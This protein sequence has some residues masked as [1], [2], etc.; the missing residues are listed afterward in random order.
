VTDLVLQVPESKNRLHSYLWVSVIEG[1]HHLGLK[2]SERRTFRSPCRS[3]LRRDNDSARHEAVVQHHVSVRAFRNYVTPT[4]LVGK[5]V[6][7][8]TSSSVQRYR[9]V[10]RT[11]AVSDYGSHDHAPDLTAAA[12]VPH[13][14][15]A[16]LVSA[17]GDWRSN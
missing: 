1:S 12:R 14:Q 15:G 8:L 9:S 7:V 6:R 16:A 13:L 4:V 10:S 5:P 11:D 2:G 17:I 3:N